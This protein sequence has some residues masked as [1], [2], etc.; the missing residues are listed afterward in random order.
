MNHTEIIQAVT[1]TPL[2]AIDLQKKF[3]VPHARVVAVLQYMRKQNMVIAVKVGTKWAW[4]VPGYVPEEVV[5]TQPESKKERMKFLSTV[6][7]NWGRQ[8]H[9]ASQTNTDS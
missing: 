5:V 8:S 3:K 2:T 1:A 7:N 4:T 9:E 6:F